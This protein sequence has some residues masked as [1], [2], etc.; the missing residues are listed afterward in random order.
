MS[1]QTDFAYIAGFLDGEGTIHVSNQLYLTVRIRNTDRLV[2]E[3]VKSIMGDGNLY[4]CYRSSYLPFHSLEFNCTKAITVL[5]CLLPYL[6]IKR[7]QAQL[8]FEFQKR[9]QG[10]SFRTPL[11]D[12]ERHSRKAIY[13][14]MR[15]L[16]QTRQLYQDSLHGNGNETV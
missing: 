5:K 15:E 6:R 1:K 7:K 4:T 16:N 3:W 14:Q 2:L 12:E 10:A 13:H 9:P 8:A 11:T